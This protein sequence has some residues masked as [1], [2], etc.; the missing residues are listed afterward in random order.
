MEGG[1]ANF[2]AEPARPSRKVMKC[3]IYLHYTQTSVPA[4]QNTVRVQ[5]KTISLILMTEII[6][7]FCEKNTKDVHK[8]TVGNN[9]ELV[10]ATQCGTYRSEPSLH[11]HRIGIGYNFMLNF[12]KRGNESITYI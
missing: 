3:D 2:T 9:A 1:N 12:N 5:N 7:V 11:E 8:Y 10:N 4:T 6:A